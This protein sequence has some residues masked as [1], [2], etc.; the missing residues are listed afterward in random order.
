MDPKLLITKDEGGV[1]VNSTEFK[2]LV[3]GLRYLVH[4]CPDLAYAVGIVSHFM[5]RP[6]QMHLNAVKRILQ[7]VKGT[8]NYGLVYSKDSKNKMISGY[9]NSDHDG[10]LEDR[11]S[12]AGMAFYLNECLISWVSQKQKCVALSSCEAEF[13]AATAAACQ[14]IWLRNLLGNITDNVIGPVV[15]YVDNRECVERGEIV[16]KN[17]HTGEQKADVL[18]KALSIVKFERMCRLLGVKDLAQESC[19]IKIG[20]GEFVVLHSE[21]RKVLQDMIL[22]NRQK[23][24]QVPDFLNFDGI[25]D[26]QHSTPVILAKLPSQG[27]AVKDLQ[28]GQVS[29]AEL[30]QAV[31]EMLSAADISM[32]VEKQFF[33]QTTLTLQEQL[34]ESQAEL[35]LEQ[36]RSDMAAKE[37]DSAKAP[38]QCRVAPPPPNEAH[39]KALP[40]ASSY[41][42]RGSAHARDPTKRALSHTEITKENFEKEETDEEGSLNTKELEDVTRTVDLCNYDYIPELSDGEAYVPP[43]QPML[44]GTMYPKGKKKTQG[45]TLC[46]RDL[47]TSLKPHILAKAI[48]RYQVEGRVILP[49]KH[50]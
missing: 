39:V 40:D 3:G 28:H 30:V 32:D 24:G 21:D 20:G 13:M 42:P 12:T 46:C 50:I 18:T 37:A 10:N 33:L 9:S 35:L 36:E 25:V 29:A 7:Y 45:L 31:H 15:L 23:F 41:S 47:S 49:Q 8:L 43:R 22:R 11:K 19:G 48:E 17:V 34:K 2:S 26:P 5:E 16:I 4:T 14:G 27:K 38:W 1:A 44:E 6:T